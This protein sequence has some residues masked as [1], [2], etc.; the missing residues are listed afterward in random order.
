MAPEIYAVKVWPV[1]V[2][3]ACTLVPSAAGLAAAVFAGANLDALA[4]V[5]Q[6][7]GVPR[8]MLLSLWTG[9]IATILSL[10]LAHA[11]VAMAVTGGWRQRL[12]TLS[13]PLLAL[14]HLA[15]GIGLV[16]VLAPSGLLMRGISPWLSG[17]DMP[18]DWHIV[19]DP[20]GLT[21]IFGLV[22]KE[23]CFLIM[24]L[25]AALAQV[26]VAP[27]LQRAASLGYGPLK[28][29]LV[30]IAPSCQQQIGLPV[31][32]V[33]VYGVGNVDLALTLGPDLPPTFAVIL[34]RW[35][36]DPSPLIQSQAHAGT[37][38]LLVLTLFGLLGLWAA[39][40][41]CRALVSAISVGGRRQRRVR[42]A[43]IGLSGVAVIGW[44]VGGLAIVAIGLR[45]A[46]GL[47]RF[48]A[49]LPNGLSFTSWQSSF[50]TALST[51]PMTAG[52]AVMSTLVALVLVLLGAEQVRTN[53]LRRQQ[54]GQW[55]FVPL[56]LPQMTFLFGVQVLLVWIGIDGTALAVTW[57]HLI[58]V[59]PYM[60]G[61]LAPAR[62]AVDPRYEQRVAS[63][64]VNRW[65]GWWRV[66]RPLLTR[67][68]LLSCAL[69]ASVSLSLYL[70][71]LFA[72]AGRIATAATEAAAAA[73]AGTLRLAAVH[74][75]LL[76]LGP[77]CAFS[78][79]YGLGAV[80]YRHRKDVP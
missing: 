52:L 22:I 11:L 79:A 29:W 31:A 68:M 10:G 4:A 27:R 42:P 15:L 64:G 25:F 65:S 59:L 19:R 58:F 48:P 43:R 62:A 13:L 72:G 33:F 17:L 74:G 38:L 36:L 40:R 67:A 69:G 32:A 56:L 26:P 2:L 44:V 49:V 80:L 18:P 61:V 71:T 30:T 34:W 66:T 63:L 37:V 20:A 5:L 28:G 39:G 9:G 70:P 54:L 7:P 6:A 53:P 50:S 55:L 3:L 76:S 45:S 41:A 46:G 73:G 51:L 77:L 75:I 57:M 35:L 47:W 1:T 12:T 21:L 16:L 78:A 60:W 23:T 14:P 8:A 24:A